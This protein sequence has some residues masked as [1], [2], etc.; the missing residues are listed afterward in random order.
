[1]VTDA[2]PLH[3]GRTRAR[4][5]DGYRYARAL[6]VIFLVTAVDVFNL[7]DRASRGGPTR[8]AILLVPA[9]AAL[10]IRTRG[11]TLVRRPRTHE[12]LLLILFAFGLLG[13]TYG[14]V[15]LHITST[16]RAIFL[17]MSIAILA[18]LV[19]EPIREEEARRLV[20]LIAWIGT[21]YIVLGAVTYSG[22]AESLAAYRQFK[23]A[24][25]PYTMLGISAALLLGHRAWAFVLAGLTAVIFFGYPSATSVLIILVTA[26]TFFA[27]STRA[28]RTRPYLIA[29]TILAIGVAGL[30]NFNSSVEIADRY[31]DAVGKRN[32]TA[33]R[34]E[35]WTNG[36]AQWRASPLIG[37][38]FASETVIEASRNRRSPYHNDF[39]L[40]LAEGG[41]VGCALFVSWLV[42]LLRDLL[43]RYFAF[44]DSGAVSQALLARLL[45][46]GLGS[47]V[48]SMLFNPVIQGLSRSAT[49]FALAAISTALGRPESVPAETA[50]ERRSA[51]VP[52]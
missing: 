4:P 25:F 46:V 36:L 6:L 35:F 8:Y 17:P 47:Y 44:A 34:L 28:S 49:I 15:F 5:S 11:S 29:A 7:L 10:A 14:I 3:A 52:A 45:L 2:P 23:N 18:L 19:I 43:H 20:R 16:A 40:F 38:G 30:V 26:L 48:V 33:G 27:T 41:I 1:M 39:V 13:T 50:L 12:R 22:L 37:S 42:L 51:L 32:T 24:S 21:I 31:F 9:V